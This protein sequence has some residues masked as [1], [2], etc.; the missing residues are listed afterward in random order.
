MASR[1]NYY[2]GTKDQYLK[3]PEHDANGLYFCENTRELFKGDDLYTGSVRYADTYDA[4]PPYSEAADAVLYFCTDKG[5]GYV[6]NPSRDGWIWVIR[7]VDNL[8]IGYDDAGHLT[9]K[10]VSID[11]VEG[12]SERLDEM[13]K[14]ID[15]GSSGDAPSGDYLPLSGGDMT[16]P[17]GLHGDP[18]EDNHAVSKDYLHRCLDEAFSSIIVI[19]GGNAEV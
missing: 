17:L 1:V 11:L 14:R 12:L 6:L 8:T 19:H 13:D 9:V 18:I 10:R 15:Q 4:L 16:G 7:S 5:N 3:L 2:K